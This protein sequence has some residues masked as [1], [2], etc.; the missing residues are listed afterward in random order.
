MGKISILPEILCNQIAAGEVVERPAAVVKELVENS[1]DAGSTKISVSLLQGG[2]KEMR[3]TD[4]GCGMNPED[5]LLALDRHATSKLRSVED[6]GAIATLGF[7]GEAIP[8]IAAVSRFELITREHP[9]LSGVHIR[10]EGGVIKDVREKGCPAGTQ[11]TVR[12]LFYNVPARRK[13]L[14]TVE[15]ELSYISDGFLRIAMAHPEI[16][17]QLISQERALYDFPRGEGL[18]QRAAQVLGLEV[19]RSLTPV[20]FEREDLQVSG[21][22]SSPDVQRTNAQSLFLFVNGR[23]VWDKLLQRT[24][25]NAY[26]ALIPRGKFPVAV[27]F[28]RIPP[29]QVDVNVHPTKREIR[30]RNPG[31]VLGGVRQVLLEI[32]SG[33]RPKTYGFAPQEEPIF[34]RRFPSPGYGAARETQASFQFRMP[35]PVSGP[36]AVPPEIGHIGPAERVY[37]APGPAE[38][39]PSPSPDLTERREPFPEPVPGEPSE[40]FRFSSLPVLGQLSNAFILLEA[41]DGLIVVDQHAAH[42]RVLFNELS[43]QTSHASQ[44]LTRPAVFHLLPREA[45]AL[46]K[47]TRA[48]TEL[49]FEIEPFGGSSFAVHSVPAPL[50]DCNPEDVLRD[51]LRFAEDEGLAS[52]SSIL[53]GL[54]KV[55]SCHGAIR[56]GQKLR[57][58]EIRH[59][60]ATLDS[61]EVPFTCPHGRP[62]FFKLSYDQIC[63][64]FKRT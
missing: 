30:F 29:D 28:L 27:L 44:M 50:T 15:T 13:F 17:V 2:R 20:E 34:T 21:F 37:V 1:I 26:E 45:A 55:A 59:L 39:I 40:E 22:L 48:L 58:E 14:R 56:A 38:E 53:A 46:G 51:F 61:T 4:N 64:L 49:G 19:S 18:S 62:L 25:M 5:A 9:I 60:L 57:P 42:E 33:I 36:S 31:A 6:L 23:P 43:R 12:D 8:S 63:R 16:H 41:P 35:S 24:V 10:I 54:V 47:W 52:G 3:V 11:V 32:L 7:R